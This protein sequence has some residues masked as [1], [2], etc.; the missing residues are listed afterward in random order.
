MTDFII[1][2]NGTFLV[3]EIISEAQEN[4]TIIALDGAADRLKR[5]GIMPQIILGD[6]DNDTVSFM[7]DWG[8]KHRFDESQDDPAPYKGNHGALIV[9]KNDQNFTDLVKAIRYC[10]EEAATSITI[11]C[12]LGGRLDHH[13]SAI[14]SLRSEY[15]TNRPI[16]LHSE[17]QTLRFAKDE[18]VVVRGEIGDKCGI[19]LSPKDI[20]HPRGLNMKVTI[21]ILDSQKALA[22]H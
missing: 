11:I 22:T 19:W 1:I 7:Q 13:E 9:P 5:L 10:D 18:T 17:Q 16:L 21:W 2:A 14:R 20:I 4:K 15:K 12:A 8:I 3:K 6:F